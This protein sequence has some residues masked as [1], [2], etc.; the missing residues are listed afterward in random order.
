M[1]EV[2]IIISIPVPLLVLVWLSV[3]VCMPDIP[4]VVLSVL[5]GL[6]LIT[7]LSVLPVLSLMPLAAVSGFWSMR[8]SWAGPSPCTTAQN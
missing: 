4:G 3:L 1:S 6:E 2:V 7:V 5:P 8:S